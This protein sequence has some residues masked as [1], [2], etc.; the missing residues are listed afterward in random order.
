MG[1]VGEGIA[2][3]VKCLR[4]LVW[5]THTFNRDR[6]R[7]FPPSSILPLYSL[8]FLN[9]DIRHISFKFT[10]LISSGIF[11]SEISAK[12]DVGLGYIQLRVSGIKF[13]KWMGSE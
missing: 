13:G 9:C 12:S 8:L 7:L 4:F 10:S 1:R 11:Q 6:V 5:M 2:K 3:D